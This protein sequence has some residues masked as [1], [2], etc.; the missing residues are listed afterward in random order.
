MH[1]LETIQIL[2]NVTGKYS[3]LLLYPDY[4]CDAYPETYLAHVEARN[5]REAVEKARAEAL[6]A[7]ELDAEYALDFAVEL[8]CSGHIEDLNPGTL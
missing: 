8:V 7:N 2:N 1:G 3:V 6:R 4:L 5:V